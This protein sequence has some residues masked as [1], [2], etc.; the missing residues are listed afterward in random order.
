M[1]D[2]ES[3]KQKMREY[4]ANQR[5]RQQR[6]IKHNIPNH[7]EIKQEDVIMPP[8]PIYIRQP[9]RPIGINEPQEK[10]RF[11]YPAFGASML[12]VSAI[13]GYLVY[14]TPSIQEQLYPL[15]QTI[16]E[17]TLLLVVVAFLLSCFL[18][19]FIRRK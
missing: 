16:P 5:E 14:T 2:I 9:Q 15:I 11:N 13:F 18:M 7:Q 17:S 8:Q 4:F 3:G 19:L 12:V 1:G 10:V 6:P